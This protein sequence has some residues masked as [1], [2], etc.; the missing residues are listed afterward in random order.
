MKVQ[1]NFSNFLSTENNLLKNM[2]LNDQPVSLIPIGKS[3]IHIKKSHEG[4]FTEYC[5]GKVTDAKIQTAKKSSNPKIRKMAI[6]AENAR[7]W[8]HRLGGKFAKGGEINE[9]VPGSTVDLSKVFV[10]YTGTPSTFE[11]KQLQPELLDTPVYSKAPE[12]ITTPV[13]SPSFQS[14]LNSLSNSEA[15]QTASDYVNQAS[16]KTVKFCGKDI[17][18]QSTVDII[19]TN[20][21]KQPKHT[22][23]RAV[24]N[25]LKGQSDYHQSSGFANPKALYDQLKKDGW[26]DVYSEN[27]TPQEGDVYTIWNVGNGRYDMHASIYTNKKGFVSYGQDNPKSSGQTPY[28]WDRRNNKG[29]QVHIMRYI[30]NHKLGGVLKFISGGLINEYIPGASVDLSKNFAE[31]LT[32]ST[33]EQ[34]K[35]DTTLQDIYN[36]FV[37]QGTPLFTPVEKESNKK[38]IVEEAPFS[39]LTK[40]VKT[41]EPKTS[42]EPTTEEKKVEGKELP[43]TNKRKGTYEATEAGRRMFVH[44]LNK[45]FEENGVKNEELRKVLVGQAALE[46]GYGSASLG[47]GDYNYGNLTTGSSWKGNYRVANDKDAHGAWIKQKFRSYNSLDEYVKDKLKFIGLNSHY[48][49]DISKDTPETYIDKIVKGGYAEDPNYRE[50]LTLMYTRDINRRWN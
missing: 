13:S 47:G 24:A 5:G 44:D 12:T 32:P 8:K 36:T 14:Q 11:R 45:A 20:L 10:D 7:G 9:Y 25:A 39:G 34:K 1:L 16:N 49:V 30:N 35:T 38:E 23:T 15:V 27:Y 19:L 18:L 2:N 40:E 4:K 33:Y 3:G 31:Y 43:P 28:F 17:N 42:E 37:I 29:S 50:A 41:S 21:D 46:S 48:K 26:T 6:F 22:C